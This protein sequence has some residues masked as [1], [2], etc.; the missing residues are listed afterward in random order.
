M[1]KADWRAKLAE[2][3]RQ[4]PIREGAPTPDEIAQRAAAVLP[5]RVGVYVAVESMRPI[6]AVGDLLRFDVQLLASKIFT[7]AELRDALQA[8][9]ERPKDRHDE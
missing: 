9:F 7:E 1:E 3:A 6:G 4:Q 5:D 2:L 8:G